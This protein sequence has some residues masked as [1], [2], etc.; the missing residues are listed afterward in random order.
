MRITTAIYVLTSKEASQT[1][2][3]GKRSND[4]TM[5]NIESYLTL[6]AGGGLDKCN[7]SSGK[8]LC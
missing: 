4:R 2:I 5:N 1:Y 8:A 7:D 3:E 6:G